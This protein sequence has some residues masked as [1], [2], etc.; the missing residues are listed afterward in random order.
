MIYLKKLFFPQLCHHC[1]LECENII[2]DRCLVGIEL[3]DK[4]NGNVAYLFDHSI[5]LFK[6]N[7]SLYQKIISSF[8]MVRLVNLG[9]EFGIIEAEP[10]LEGIKK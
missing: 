2:C 10:R 6:K 4:T 5:E 1:Y 9:W 3:S 7:R 8:C